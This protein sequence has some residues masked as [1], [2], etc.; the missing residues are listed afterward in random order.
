MNKWAAVFFVSVITLVDANMAY[1]QAVTEAPVLIERVKSG[2]LPAVELR[3]PENPLRVRLNHDGLSPGQYGGNLRMLMG[4]SKDVR[5]MVVYGYA[6]LIGYNR[7]LKL[8]SDIAQSIDVKEGRIFTIR[9]RKGH[10]WSDGQPFTSEDFRYFW[11][12]VALNRDLSPLGPSKIMR[13]DGEL[14]KFE[15][16]DELTVRYQWSRP[17]PFFLSALA[18]AAPLFIYR[19]AHYLKQFHQRYQNAKKL[20][21][22]VKKQRR[23]NWVALHYSKDRQYANDNPDMPSLQPWVNTTRPPSERFV[24]KRNP[25][26]YRVDQLGQQLPYI[27]Q[28][29]IAIA[30][31]KLIPAKVGSGDADLQARSLLFKNYTFLKR[32][33]KRNNY[34]VRRWINAKGSQIALY[35][36]LNVKDLVW[37]KLLRQVDFRRALSLGINRREINQVVF[38][39]LASEGSNTVLPESPLYKEQ[40]AE[41]YAR[42]DAREA[43]RLLDGIG[44]KNRT[45]DGYRKLADGRPLQIIVETPGEDSEQADVLELINDSWKKIGIKMFIKPT[46]RETL[47]SRVLSG[48]TVMSIFYGLDNGVPTADFAPR[49]LVPTDETNLQWPRWGAYAASNGKGGDVPDTPDI[50]RM[51]ELYNE[52]SGSVSNEQRKRIWQDMLSIYSEQVY[53]IGL[54]A[55]VPQPIVVNNNLMNVPAKGIYNWDPGAHF[56]IYKPDTFWFRKGG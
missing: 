34:T 47:R 7:K 15:V 31:P 6:R 30:S 52:W 50:L 40:Y 19:P 22:M 56:G 23:R 20:A 48:L 44:L 38:F 45:P 25:F 14:P 28:V 35:P 53:S 1:A 5:L 8:Q 2:Q 24:F 11:Q 9:L 33:E 17:N 27:D 43:N 13:V 4:R 32:G 37:R 51:L 26:Y 42:F 41:K 36:N 46:R 3:L 39:G 29:T 12:D 16:I 55:G 10:R 49:E 54:V 21:A 18:G